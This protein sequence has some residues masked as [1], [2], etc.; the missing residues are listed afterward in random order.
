MKVFI[1]PHRRQ[2]YVV[3]TFIEYRNSEQNLIQGKLRC[4]KRQSFRTTQHELLQNLTK[5]FF[6][7]SWYVCC[8]VYVRHVKSIIKWYK[9][10]NLLP[11]LLHQLPWFSNLRDKE[12]YQMNDQSIS[13]IKDLFIHF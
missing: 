13:D 10:R 7:K 6:G 12:L 2:I 11:K 1:F 4:F 8:G 5:T 3:D 9:R